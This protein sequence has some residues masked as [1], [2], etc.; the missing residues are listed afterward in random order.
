[1]LE[2]AF[3]KARRLLAAEQVAIVAIILDEME[4][5]ARCYW[6]AWRGFGRKL[7]NVKVDNGYT[8]IIVKPGEDV[9]Q[10]SIETKEIFQ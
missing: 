4:D 7:Y 5:E 9:K 8:T 2:Q 1:M 6:G 3:E 10:R